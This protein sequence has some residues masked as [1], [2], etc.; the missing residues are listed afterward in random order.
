MS[1]SGSVLYL[2]FLSL[3]LSH[4]SCIVS[5]AA[6]VPQCERHPDTRHQDHQHGD[7]EAQDEEEDGVVKIVRALPVWSTAHTGGLWGELSPAW[8][9]C[10][11][12]IVRF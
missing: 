7:D 2:V 10:I 9:Q 3:G 8:Q 6:V 12:Q 4:H 11:L 5:S 1:G